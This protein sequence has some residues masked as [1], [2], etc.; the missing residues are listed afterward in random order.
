MYKVTYLDENRKGFSNTEPWILDEFENINI[1]NS[2]ADRLIEEGYKDVKVI[3]VKLITWQCLKKLN[4]EELLNLVTDI[5][6]GTSYTVDG[7][8]DI[9]P[10]D[11]EILDYAGV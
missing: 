2:E 8:E 4:N 6:N 1:A 11:E 10:T 3:P 9:Y 7:Y 5:N